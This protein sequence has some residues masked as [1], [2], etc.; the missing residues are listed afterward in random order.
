MK[1]GAWE[2]Y[3]H[4]T[5]L[6]QNGKQYSSRRVKVIQYSRSPCKTKQNKM[7]EYNT[8]MSALF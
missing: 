5:Q 1:I 6:G 8:F 2:S 4:C 7:D 3:N